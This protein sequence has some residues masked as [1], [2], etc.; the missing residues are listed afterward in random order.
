[1][2][3]TPPAKSKT[4]TRRHSYLFVVLRCLAGELAR[5]V[6]FRLSLGWQCNCR[7]NENAASKLAG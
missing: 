5:R 7:P 2:M 4:F 3:P 6:G 1:M